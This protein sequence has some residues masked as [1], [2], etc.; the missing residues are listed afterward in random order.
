MEFRIGSLLGAHCRQDA[1][2]T[3]LYTLNA[4]YYKSGLQGFSL[5]ILPNHD[6]LSSPYMPRLIYWTDPDRV[7]IV[8]GELETVE[9]PAS[10]NA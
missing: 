2:G 1:D 9:S 5:R 6:Y 8:I 3:S 4:A 10:V 7:R